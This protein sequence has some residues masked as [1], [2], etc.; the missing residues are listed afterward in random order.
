MELK[1]CQLCAVDFTLEHF[2]LPLVDG[3]R[4][5]GWQV[6]AVCSDGPAIAGL[7]ELGYDIETVR[8]ERS[9][10][11]F[12]HVSS[13]IGLVRLFKARRFDVVHVHT[14]V[15]ALI[16]RF[17][18]RIAGVPLVVY[19][20]HGF[21][22][23]DDMSRWKRR[24]F[25]R[26]EKLG[27]PFTDLLFTQSEED[28]RTAVQERIAPGGRVLAIGNGV[29]PILFDPAVVGSGS[30]LREALGIRADEFVIGFI[31]RHVREKGIAEFLEAA[32]LV[33]GRYP[34]VRFLVIGERLV[35]DHASGVDAELEAAELK[36]GSRMIT[37]GL[38]NDIPQCLAAMDVFCLPSWREGMPRTII[39]AMMM[40]KPVI[41]TDIRGSREEVLHE[42]TGI[43]VPVRSPGE[44]AA[45][46]SR[47]VENP[48][49]AKDLGAA[50]RVRAL[51]LY[52]ER[53]I[54]EIQLDRIEHLARI[55]RLC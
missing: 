48:R 31:G 26:L 4:N 39:E 22:F 52:D 30:L 2:L 55:F 1:V 27:T 11:L 17:A 35:S 21:Y 54:V 42:S 25:I 40:G 8:I 13:I 9:F 46:M 44:L 3:M 50:A 16:G 5:Y 18:A 28:A 29:D 15:A 24:L 32:E 49:W 20:A 23:H 7:R 41:A 38:R 53:R 6:T 12:H 51:S 36:L 33:A 10:N 14:P 47:F 43:L 19:T 34:N 37:T 45:A